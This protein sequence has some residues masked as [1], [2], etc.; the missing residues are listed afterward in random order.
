[1][2]A[3]WDYYGEE[4]V[5]EVLLNAPSLSAKAIAYFSNQFGVPREH[6]RAWS[7]R[8]STWPS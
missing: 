6:F 3:V 4:R 2:R 8:S 5:R 7:R 1:V